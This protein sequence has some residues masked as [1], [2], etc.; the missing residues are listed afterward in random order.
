MPSRSSS[1]AMP[2]RSDSA[3]IVLAGGWGR[4][5]G[6]VPKAMVMLNGQPLLDHVVNRLRP[7]IGLIAISSN[8][9][10]DGE[11]DLPVLGDRHADRR[12][13]LAGI[14]AGMI[15]C[16]ANHPDIRRLLS[17]P[18]DG[19][20]LPRDLAARLAARAEETGAEVVVAASANQDH[21]TLALWD[22]ALMGSLG[23]VL[24]SG[25]DLSVRHFY[26]GRRLAR[27]DFETGPMDP[28]FNINTPDDL[29]RAAALLREVRDMRSE[30]VIEP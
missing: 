11:L 16:K 14:L 15:W 25:H 17:V 24:E 28:F 29:A 5:M 21:P 6:R 19:P 13:P 3:A 1:T 4:R 9:P 12:G 7:Q 22:V 10:V 20:F 26:E 2:A 30:N 8:D 18:V 23:G 27:V